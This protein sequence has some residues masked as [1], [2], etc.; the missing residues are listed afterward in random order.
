MSTPRFTYEPKAPKVISILKKSK[1]LMETQKTK[2]IYQLPLKFP[3]F[4]FQQKTDDTSGRNTPV[5]STKEPMPENVDPATKIRRWSR[6]FVI[7]V[8]EKDM[9]EI[10][11]KQ[12][13]L[14]EGAYGSVTK[15]YNKLTK[16][17]V[18]LKKVQRINE[19]LREPEILRYLKDCVGILP[20][21]KIIVTQSNLWMEF[22]LGNTVQSWIENDLKFSMLPVFLS[23]IFAKSIDLLEGLLY[24]HK[25]G[26]IHRDIKFENVLFYENRCCYIDLGFSKRTFQSTESQAYEVVTAYYRAP[27]VLFYDPN[28]QDSYYTPAIDLWA[29]GIVIFEMCVSFRPFEVY[30]TP[31]FRLE[32]PEK[33]SKEQKLKIAMKKSI[34]EWCEYLTLSSPANSLSSSNQSLTSQGTSKSQE[35][36]ETIKSPSFLKPLISQESLNNHPGNIF[37]KLRKSLKIRFPQHWDDQSIQILTSIEYILYGLLQ[38]KPQERYLPKNLLQKYNIKRFPDHLFEPDMF[39][40]KVDLPFL[41]SSEKDIWLTFL[42]FNQE[43]ETHPKICLFAGL[44][45]SKY[46]PLVHNEQKRN[47]KVER[48]QLELFSAQKIG[49]QFFVYNDGMKTFAYKFLPDYQKEPEI[50]DENCQRL[51][52]CY[53]ALSETQVFIY[54]PLY[55][56]VDQEKN[57]AN[58]YKILSTLFE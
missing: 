15:C 57:Y 23:Q 33:T 14:G 53:V 1:D 26:V 35:P 31:N 29:L 8:N 18:A 55:H 54:H 51:E 11:I 9:D 28:N 52:S 12:S 42:K 2:S 38:Y 37:A 48:T 24:L 41:S 40:D 10:Y 45:W 34:D 27:E 43:L 17:I 32:F 4:P 46:A 5:K 25:K 7:I 39:P 21:T 19:Y 56:K 47:E 13:Q 49:Y 50:F 20:L 44:L 58:M 36:T 30:N 3:S 6:F 16:Q 22:P